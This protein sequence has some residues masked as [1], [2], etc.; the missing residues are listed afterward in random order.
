MKLS[1]LINGL[2]EFKWNVFVIF[3]LFSIIILPNIGRESLE[4][5]EI[6]TAAV[7]LKSTSL[8]T[9]ISD[10]ILKDV[11]PP[12]FYITLYYWGKI[13]GSSDFEIRLLCFLLV[14]ASLYISYLVLK[15]HY[16]RKVAFIF[17]AL[18]SFTPGVLFYAQQLRMYALLYSLA[19]IACILFF[20][21]ITK[22]KN[23]QTIEKNFLGIYFFLGTLLCYTHFTGYLIVFSLSLLVIIYSLKLKSHK[24]AINVFITSTGIALL[25]FVWLFIHF[26]YGGLATKTQGNFTVVNDF[27][28]TILNFSTLLATNKFGVLIIVILF[29]PFFVPFTRLLNAIKK[30][31]VLLYPTLVLLI[32]AYLISLNTPILT[33]YNLIAIIPL[34]LLFLAFLFSELYDD[35]KNYIFLFIVGLFMIGTYS[36]CTYKKQNW[37]DASRYIQNNFDS[38]TCVIP[39]KSNRLIFVSYYLGTDYTYSNKG[40]K[41]QKNCDLIYIDGHTNEAGIRN[42]L[43]K[44]N[45]A[46]PFEILNFDK[47]FVV[48]KKRAKK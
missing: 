24:N 37:R 38:K 30:Y 19:N 18:S 36:S 47:V 17:V 35:K 43:A 32:T 23:N 28:S 14:L 48:I 13:V 16:S 7:A 21:F 40:P 20:I 5:D 12:L 27:K 15:K 41:I 45:I 29:I 8:N 39:I 42:A 9:M 6:W 1:N 26:Y 3:I 2:F 33:Y 44:N 31:L 4:H 25:G 46:I 34:L 10:F 11:H 22:I